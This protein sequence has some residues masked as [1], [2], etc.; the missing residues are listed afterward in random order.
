MCVAVCVCVCVYLSVGLS[1]SVQTQR[2]EEGRSSGSGV[3]DTWVLVAPRGCWVLNRDLLWSENALI[4]KPV[5][6]CSKTSLNA[7][8]THRRVMNI[9]FLI[10]LPG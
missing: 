10:F 8:I 5:S 2:P 1:V 3:T 6:R 9:H 4:T 7:I